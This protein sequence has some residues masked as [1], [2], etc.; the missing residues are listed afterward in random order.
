M[1]VPYGNLQYETFGATAIM[2]SQLVPVP[3]S[4]SGYHGSAGRK[5]YFNLIEL[6]V[7]LFALHL[8]TCAEI[9]CMPQCTQNSRE[10]QRLRTRGLQ[11]TA[12]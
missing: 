4:Q 9:Q 11:L 5:I 2:E 10:E 3:S 8:S 1:H 7:G 6:L 12:L